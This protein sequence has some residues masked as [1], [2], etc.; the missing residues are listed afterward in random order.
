MCVTEDIFSQH[1]ISWY[2]GGAHDTSE[3]RS[4][5]IV[6]AVVIKAALKV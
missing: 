5:K 3:P 1:L 2:V 4:P 6:S